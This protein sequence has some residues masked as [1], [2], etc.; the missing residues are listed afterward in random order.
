MIMREEVI[1]YIGG[2]QLPDKN[3]AALRVMS[4]AKAFRELGYTVVFINALVNYEYEKP[5]WINYDGFRT[6]NYQRENQLIYIL[7]SKN[8]VAMLKELNVGIVIAYNYPSV[9]LNKIRKYCQRRGIKCIADITEWYVPSGNN[10]IYRI[11][12]GFDTFYRMRYVQ[13]KMD[14]VITISQ[15]LYQYYSHKVNTVKIPPLVDLEEEKWKVSAK[16]ISDSVKFIYAGSPSV[17]KE[18]LD[19]IIKEIEALNVNINIHLNVLGITKEQF[20]KMYKQ[21]YNGKRVSFY[22]R[23]SNNTA[24]KMTKESDWV[25]ILRNKN[26]VVQAG[27]PTKV[28]E[29]VACGTPVIAND[30]SNIRDYLNKEN[31]I[32][33]ET[34]YDF[35]NALLI[36]VMNKK[37]HISNKV[38]D[39]REYISE[40][41][42]LLE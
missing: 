38:F 8:I 41:K 39:Y 6:R 21:N 9:A 17:Q 32:L 37:I 3:A 29:A 16:K 24:I 36:A 40:F 34:P 35:K 26:R 4:N 31:S 15:Y 2:F 30:F 22:G 7:S 11:I 20:N 19:L 23:V 28:A 25:V 13:T 42:R 1:L 10:L 12:K 33:I 27:F 18:C 5:E 14:A